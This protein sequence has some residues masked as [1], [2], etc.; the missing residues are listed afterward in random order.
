MEATFQ[1]VLAAARENKWTRKQTRGELYILNCPELWA[2]RDELMTALG[3]ATTDQTATDQQAA[4]DNAAREA[5]EQQEREAAAAKREAALAA[6]TDGA[7]IFCDSAENTVVKVVNSYGRQAKFDNGGYRA[8]LKVGDFEAVF[9]NGQC[10]DQ[11]A[12]ECWAVLKAV[13]FAKERGL[14]SCTV[15]NDRIGGFGACNGKS[16]K[17]G[18][19]GA[20]YLYVA[21]KIAEEHGIAVQFDLCTSDTNEADRVARKPGRVR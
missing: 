21:K 12:G 11:F 3:F 2:R 8:G 1:A 7:I 5:G 10:P 9:Y 19:I 18:Y 17:R 15:R 13:E 16:I 4:A 6:I 20:K 14:K